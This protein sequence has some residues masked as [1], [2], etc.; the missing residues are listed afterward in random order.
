MD[1]LVNL[2]DSSKALQ[3]SLYSTSKTVTFLIRVCSVVTKIYPL[4]TEDTLNLNCHWSCKVIFRSLQWIAP[5]YK[6]FLCI[7]QELIKWEVVL[8]GVYDMS[9]LT[10]IT[11]DEADTLLDDSFHSQVTHFI[12]R[13]PVRR[14]M[15]HLAGLGFVACFMSCFHCWNSE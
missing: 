3:N 9:Y 12:T 4:K 1:I 13:Q 11:L 10:H 6:T 15:Y 5:F 14:S 7:E 8:S 2:K